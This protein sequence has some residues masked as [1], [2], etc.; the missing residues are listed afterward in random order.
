MLD[1]ESVFMA[2][3]DEVVTESDFDL[4]QDE[5]GVGDWG[6][7]Q[8]IRTEVNKELEKLRANNVIGS[9]LAANVN[10]YID[11]KILPV[12]AKLKD[13]L[14]FI[15]ITSSATIARYFAGAK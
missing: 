4:S 13:D 7:I 3:W 6:D 5:I 8:S 12:L 11:D 10:L 14:R 15:L 2:R 9:S 1:K